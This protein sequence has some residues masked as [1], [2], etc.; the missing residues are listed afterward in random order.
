MNDKIKNILRDRTVGMF[1]EEWYSETANMI[2]NGINSDDSYGFL[3]VIKS[4]LNGLVKI[5][6]TKN[7]QRRLKD[8]SN[9][10][11]E[12]IIISI[13]E[14]NDY[15]NLEK[16]FHEEFK[17]QREHGEWFG[18]KDYENLYEFIYKNN[19]TLCNRV[20]DDS[21]N[22]SNISFLNGI[23][24]S[25]NTNIPI[26][27]YNY[28]ISIGIHKEGKYDKSK[29]FDNI[30]FDHS[31]SKKKISSFAESFVN[32]KGMKCSHHRNSSTRFFVV[33]F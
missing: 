15:I 6:V 26:E 2:E 27:L 23:G 21:F 13:I 17:N 12:L 30:P 14:S 10:V 3:Y 7:P 5:G 20:F 16:L 22:I 31:Y 28:F 32:F 19:G 18:I 33:H 25:I 1:T 4:K 11:G 29:I 24:N 9:Y 8:I